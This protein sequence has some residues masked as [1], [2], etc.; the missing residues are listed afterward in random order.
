MKLTTLPPSR[1]V[2]RREG[3][4]RCKRP[5][6]LLRPSPVQSPSSE[7]GPRPSQGACPLA[8]PVRVGSVRTGP[9]D[10]RTPMPRGR[11]R[12]TIRTIT[13]PSQRALPLRPRSLRLALHLPADDPRGR[14]PRLR[15]PRP[16]RPSAAPSAWNCT[17]VAGRCAAPPWTA[18][19]GCARSPTGAHATPKAETSAHAFTGTSPAF[20]IATVSCASPPPG[21]ATRVRLVAFRGPGPRPAH[22][23][24]SHW[25]WWEEK[26]A[27]LTT[28]PWA[29]T[30]L[31]VTAL[32]TG[33][34][35][36]AHL[37][38][39]CGPGR[40]RHRTGGPGIAAASAF[41]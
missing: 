10:P 17:R 25:P 23:R 6:P 31:Q 40:P 3:R 8:E 29:W 34:R 22:P 16:R 2:H 4:S 7:A 13:P 27:P 26:R 35:R 18:S 37:R 20:L 36:A 15:R 24:P 21:S 12:S 38:P 11:S 14:P 33:E 28:A 1:R 30:N 39:S 9:S 41:G 32:D 19:P 5:L